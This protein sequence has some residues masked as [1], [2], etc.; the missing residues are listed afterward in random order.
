MAKIKSDAEWVD[1]LLEQN[2]QMKDKAMALVEKTLEELKLVEDERD[3]LKEEVSLLKGEIYRYR[4]R[5][6]LPIEKES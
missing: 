2:Q 3:L 6:G 1:S 4:K 5:L